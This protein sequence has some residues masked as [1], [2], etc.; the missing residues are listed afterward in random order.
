MSPA[1]SALS[2][3]PSVSS[4]PAF[5]LRVSLAALCSALAACHAHPAPAPISSLAGLTLPL[6]DGPVLGAVVDGAVGDQPAEIALEVVSPLS[7]VTRACFPHG[8]PESRATVKV[9]LPMGGEGKYA[10]SVLD[11]IRLG[12]TPLGTIRGAVK[13]GTTCLVTL[14]SDV[15][16]PY[17]LEIDPEHRT[18]RFSP[19]RTRADYEKEQASAAPGREVALV[20]VSLEPDSD[21]PLVTVRARQGTAELLGTFLLSTGSSFS[22]VSET[23]ARQAGLQSETEVLEASVGKNVHLPLEQIP[24]AFAPDRV[25]LRPGL[26]LEHAR[27]LAVPIRRKGLIGVLGGD[28]WGKFRATVDPRA[29]VLLLSRPAVQAQG[30]VQRCRDGERWSEEACFAISSNRRDVGVFSTVTLRRSFPD[31]G[32]VYLQPLVNG[33]P[34]A[35]G[36]RIGV[37]VPPSDRGTTISEALPWQ[38]L[39]NASPV[40]AEELSHATDM[41]FELY[42]E[43]PMVGCPGVC[44]FVTDLS[45]ERTSCACQ[46]GTVTAEAIAEQ[47]LRG[48]LERLRKQ[49]QQRAPQEEPEPEEPDETP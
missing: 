7:T 28:V 42:E 21:W 25:E 34:G 1:P 41:G 4:S 27:L 33:K 24:T 9:K 36:C 29:G 30:E 35:S 23:D 39:A 37:T 15:L 20:D 31:G 43:G 32:R 49:K 17:A 2:V 13:A 18:L 5:W 48:L 47:R 19:S 40:C 10:E 45:G 38:G 46:P 3:S 14:G 16:K 26:A 6:R 8:E 11:G 44:M 12:S 22:T